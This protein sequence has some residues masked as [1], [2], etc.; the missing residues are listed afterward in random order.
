MRK[1]YTF[2]CALNVYLHSFVCTAEDL[3]THTLHAQESRSVLVSVCVYT[4][5]SIR[6]SVYLSVCLEPKNMEIRPSMKY[7]SVG[8]YTYIL[9]YARLISMMMAD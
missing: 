7:Y 2:V 5:L 1:R 6:L 9:A 4:L 8:V 3:H